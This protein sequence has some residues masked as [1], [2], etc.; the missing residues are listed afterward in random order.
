MVQWVPRKCIQA[1]IFA[2]LSKTFAPSYDN[3]NGL[4]YKAFSQCYDNH[5]GDGDRQRQMHPE[6]K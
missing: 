5:N 3:H 6:G 2:V 4:Y 1:H